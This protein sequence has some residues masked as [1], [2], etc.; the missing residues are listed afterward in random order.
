MFNR[1]ATGDSGQPVV[2][3]EFNQAEKLAMEHILCIAKLHIETRRLGKT[4]LQLTEL[5]IDQLA[6]VYEIESP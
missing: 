4:D 5:M 3:S 2:L 1:I 6:K